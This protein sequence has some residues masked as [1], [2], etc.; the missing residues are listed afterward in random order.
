MPEVAAPV[1][2]PQPPAPAARTGPLSN[3][4]IERRMEEKLF[5]KAV[6][7]KAEDL[8]EGE[9]GEPAPEEAEVQ[10]T[11]ENDE[12]GLEIDYEAPVFDIKVKNDQ[13]QTEEVKVSLKQLEEGFMMTKD[14]HRK[15]KEL[16]ARAEQIDHELIQAIQPERERYVRG[17][18]SLRTALLHTAA[19]ELANMDMNSLAKL[20]ETDPAKATQVQIKAQQLQQLLTGID[21]EMGNQEAAAR[22][23]MAQFSMKMLSDPVKGIPNWNNDLYSEIINE[24]AE[25]YDFSPQEIA[26][27]VDYRLIKLAHDALK[28]RKID[29]AKPGLAKKLTIVPKI[30]RPGGASEVTPS[31]RNDAQ[32]RKDIKSAKTDSQ[33]ARVIQERLAQRFRK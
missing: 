8:P 19:P 9:E 20:A 31:Q 24:V 14:Y 25:A 13:G 15:A 5:G 32:Y 3:A 12:K 7:E 6:P 11:P 29:A 33:K 17:L 22:S 30:V 18:N 4:E 10:E 16:A 2:A 21:Q 23:Q 1:A 28:S 27:V 26:N